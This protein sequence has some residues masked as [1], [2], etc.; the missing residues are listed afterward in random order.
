TAERGATAGF[1]LAT[2]PPRRGDEGAVLAGAALAAG[3]GAGAAAAFFLGFAPPSNAVSTARA[4]PLGSVGISS[5]LGAAARS[6]RAGALGD[7][8]ARAGGAIE[9]LGGGGGGGASGSAGSASREA[10]LLDAARAGFARASRGSGSPNALPSAGD[11]S[12]P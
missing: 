9:G 4:S 5:C 6:S 8:A 10:R 1:L 11:G 7:R 12:S 2:A 3:L